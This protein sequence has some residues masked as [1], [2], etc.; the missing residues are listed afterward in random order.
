MSMRAAWPL[1][2]LLSISACSDPQDLPPYLIEGPRILAVRA[3]PAQTTPG[4]K[5]QREVLAVDAQGQRIAT[6][7]QFA[8]CELPKALGERSFVSQA[9]L[10]GQGLVPTQAD[11]PIDLLS[12]QRFGPSPAPPKEKDAPSPRPVPPDKTGGYYSPEKV[13]I[14]GTPLQAFYKVRTRCELLGST[15]E[16]FDAFEAQ[17][18]PNQTPTMDKG[19]L[20]PSPDPTAS[21]W[22]ITAPIGV[23]LELSLQ[24]A[25]TQ[26]ESYVRYEIPRNRIVQDRESLTL[27]WYAFGA[28]LARSEETLSPD[29]LDKDDLF[30]NTLTL[31]SSGKATLWLVLSDDRGARS[32]R[33]LLVFA[34]QSPASPP[35]KSP[36]H[37]ARSSE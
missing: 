10:V 7:P 11:A 8:R 24:V 26:A 9:C 16:V 3:E 31:G 4:Q 27:R 37:P 29:K 17:Y 36:P 19:Q 32:W 25:P 12:C 21:P 15:R 23:P 5:V 2:L 34:G 14:P 22:T 33:Q 6:P 13:W 1:V 35:T 20:T 18:H 30:R 28:T